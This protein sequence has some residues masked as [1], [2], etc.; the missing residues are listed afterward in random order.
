MRPH[1]ALAGKL[2]ATYLLLSMLWIFLSDS[3][4]G[5]LL[6]DAEQISLLQTSE[7]LLLVLL[8]GAAIAALALFLG[9]RLEQQSALLQQR[10]EQLSELEERGALGSWQYDGR[11]HGSALAASLLGSAPEATLEELLMLVSPTDRGGLQRTLLACLDARQDGFSLN[12]QLNPAPGSHSRRWLHL[13]ARRDPVTNCL[14]GTL[15]DITDQRLDQEALRDS[16]QRFRRLLEQ[17]PRI[18][19]QAYDRERRV[20]FWN[21]SSEQLY[22][23]SMSEALGQ[24]LEQLIIPEPMQA[25]VIEGVQRWIEGGAPLP[26]SELTLRRK[27]GSPVWVY[28]SHLLLR[29]RQNQAELY[30]LDIDLSELKQTSM[31]LRNSELRLRQLVEQLSEAIFIC[32]PQQVLRFVNSAWLNLHR[33]SRDDC[34][35]QP[36]WQFFQP[37]DAA[38]VQEHANAIID[39]KTQRWSRELRLRSDDHQARWVRLDIARD[40]LDG[41]LRGSISDTQ[42]QHHNLALQKARNA[43]L[44]ALLGQRPLS[45]I[46]L[47]ITRRLEQINP[48]MHTSIMLRD[49]QNRLHIAAAP[50]L[51]DTY[52]QAIEGIVASTGT[53]SCGHAV[54][55]GEL[56][57]ASNLQE[58]PYWTNYRELAAR[59][60]LQACW[61]LPFKDEQGTV[62]GTFA[63]YYR[64]PTQPGAED[65]RLVAEFTRLIVLAIEQSK[66]RCAREDSELHL[67]AM[68]EKASVAIVLLDHA[69]RILR[70]NQRLCQWLGYSAEELCQRPLAELT[71][72]ADRAAAALAFANRLHGGNT[73]HCTIVQHYECKEGGELQGRLDVSPYQQD[74]DGPL[75]FICTLQPLPDTPAETRL[76]S[77]AQP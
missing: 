52:L 60:N 31:A 45:E 51:P 54:A 13:C 8:S 17:T 43:T 73:Q 24:R 64:Q 35:G 3:L 5:F 41:G 50:S 16:E 23:Y 69:G 55:S 62:L 49:A 1:M 34:L 18:A 44:D 9:E 28:S 22:G 46:L 42:Q 71:R 2:A 48:R 77:L 66:L 33:C 19:V 7:E 40:S 68:F 74:T 39:G 36:L 25:S 32:D 65:I 38:L 67:R 30:C 56:T 6:R 75:F 29:N 76:P 70:V 59:H 26:P 47:D 12:L 4:L 11:F 53:G 72:P 14:R 63:V 37:E 58:H 21:P 57:I 20:I 10:T 61:S 27:D 15:R